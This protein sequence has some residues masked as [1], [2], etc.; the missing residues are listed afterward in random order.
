MHVTQLHDDSLQ[1]Y[2]ERGVFL[3]P[4]IQTINLAIIVPV[5]TRVDSMPLHF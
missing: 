3:I 1:V 2:Q 4:K 5:A